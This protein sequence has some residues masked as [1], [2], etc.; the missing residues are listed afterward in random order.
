MNHITLKDNIIISLETEGMFEWEQ[1]TGTSLEI[2]F[3][4]ST[5]NTRSQWVSVENVDT[6]SLASYFLYKTADDFKNMTADEFI[7][8]MLKMEETA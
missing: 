7:Q 2:T 5:P 4:T 3:K 8:D 1:F 6:L